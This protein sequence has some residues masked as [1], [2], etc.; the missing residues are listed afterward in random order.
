MKSR[1]STHIFYDL[2]GRP[3]FPTAF[4]QWTLLTQW[5]VWRYSE[6]VTFL[7]WLSK[8][9][10]GNIPL[11]TQ[12]IWT[13]S[14]VSLTP[15]KTVQKI[16]HRWRTPDLIREYHA[17]H[18]LLSGQTYILNLDK[19]LRIKD[20]KWVRHRIK[21]VHFSVLDLWEDISNVFYNEN[22][23]RVTTEIPFIEWKSLGESSLSLL[24]KMWEKLNEEL[25]MPLFGDSDWL[26]P[27][28]IK[29]T[30]IHDDVLNLTITD[31]GASIRWIMQRYQ[32]LKRSQK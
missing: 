14:I 23:P 27:K 4:R 28:N 26:N 15:Q 30:N 3:I 19:E 24:R 2:E 7:L 12:R 13:D 16:Y 22:D 20:G 31:L 25:Q 17:L 9:I 29:V 8:Y 5:L 11:S 32:Y 18:K 21:R 10:Q 6:K 1:N